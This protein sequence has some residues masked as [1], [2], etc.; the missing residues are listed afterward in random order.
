MTLQVLASRRQLFKDVAL[1]TWFRP[2]DVPSKRNI[3]RMQGESIWHSF[4]KL[5]CHSVNFPDK[6]AISRKGGAVVA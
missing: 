6:T 3:V 5:F 2:V 1:N 4:A